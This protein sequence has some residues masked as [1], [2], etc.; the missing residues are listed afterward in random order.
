MHGKICI[1]KPIGEYGSWRSPAARSA[2]W[3]KTFFIGQPARCTEKFAYVFR[4]E[5]RTGTSHP[6]PASMHRQKKNRPR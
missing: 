3:E 1:C 5:T 2:F 6:G 4:S